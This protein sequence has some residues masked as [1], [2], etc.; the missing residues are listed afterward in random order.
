MKGLLD[1]AAVSFEFKKS[2]PLIL[3]EKDNLLGYD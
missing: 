1:I 2:L 3:I